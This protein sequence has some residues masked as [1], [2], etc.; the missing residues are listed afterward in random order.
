MPGKRA[1]PKVLMSHEEIKAFADSLNAASFSTPVRCCSC[2]A[3]CSTPLGLWQ[4]MKK[5][6]ADN[7]DIENIMVIRKLMRKKKDA[8]QE[9]GAEE[10]EKEE[11][12]KKE[13]DEKAMTELEFSSLRPDGN[14]KYTMVLCQLCG[15]SVPKKQLIWHLTKSKNHKANPM[16][17]DIVKEWYSVKDGW[18]ISNKRGEQ[19]CKDFEKK[20]N[21]IVQSQAG[22]S[23][24]QQSQPPHPESSPMSD[25]LCQLIAK[26]PSQSDFAALTTAV[27]Q[28]LAAV[29]AAPAITAAAPATLAIPAAAPGLPHQHSLKEEA[30]NFKKFTKAELESKWATRK[31]YVWPLPSK[32]EILPRDLKQYIVSRTKTDKTA[33]IYWQGVHYYFCCFNI[34]APSRPTLTIY[35]E[36]VSQGLISKAMY[37]DLWS[38]DISWTS[39]M[40][41]GMQLFAD[42]LGIQAEDAGDLRGVSICSSLGKRYLQPLLKLLPSAKDA[43]DARR[44]RIDKHRRHQLPPVALQGE[45]VNWSLIDLKILCDFYSVMASEMGGIPAAARRAIYAAFL[46]V[47]SYRT[48]PGRPG[49][50]EAFPLTNMELFIEDLDAWYIEVDFHKTEIAHQALGRMI[51]PELRDILP[52]FVKFSCPRRNLLLAP[53]RKDTANISVNRALTDWAAV[54]TPG[55][56]HPEPTLYRKAVETEIAH[57]DN[58]EKAARMNELIP[59]HVLEAEQT[60]KKAAR[61]AGHRQGTAKK[62]YILENGNPLQDALTSKA[63]IEVFKGPLPPLTPAQVDARETRTAED[64]LGDFAKL[65]SRK[66]KM[67]NKTK[68]G[69]ADEVDVAGEAGNSGEANEEDG[70]AEREA[71]NEDGCGSGS[72]GDSGNND[73]ESKGE[74]ADEVG[75]ADEAGNADEADEEDGSAEGEAGNEDGCGS[76]SSS[77]FCISSSDAESKG[78]DADEVGEDGSAEGEVSNEEVPYEELELMCFGSEVIET[79]NASASSAPASVKPQRQSI[80]CGRKRKYSPG[81]DID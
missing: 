64:I 9:G 49:E 28:A 65:A 16:K 8:T 60:L 80:F 15:G 52:Q 3:A 61:M 66:K 74:D 72:H 10:E 45:A 69:D 77:A 41:A 18:K 24:T 78:E 79:A 71:G 1:Q 17:L 19:F 55:F 36:L 26:Q 39:K 58:V 51:P 44:L 76:G 68:D 21:A 46:G 14:N 11:E 13:E 25:A 40:V 30:L 56:Q 5:H 7:K 37:L 62:H 4:H 32:C 53:A 57:K 63:Y 54:Y 2:Q 35:K 33:K 43:R 27:C 29:S 34:S 23:Q 42:W 50:L 67:Q 12:E 20:H 47:Y 70:G 6:G 22:P 38:P 73:A 31:V 81:N 75:E 59:D 48:Y